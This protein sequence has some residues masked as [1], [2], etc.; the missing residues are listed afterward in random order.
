MA[1]YWTKKNS[2]K[3]STMVSQISQGI[4]ISVTSTY[5]SSS[6]KPSQR[7][8]IHA[9][10][11]T[12]ENLSE[13]TVQLIT[14]HWNIYDGRGTVREVSGPGVIGEQPVLASFDIHEYTSWCPLTTPVGKMNGTYGMKNLD[15]EAEF[16]V[17]VPEFK[18]IADHV[19]N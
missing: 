16:I 10:H 17:D 18:L 12:I 15:T 11:V 7:R 5:D 14:R 2:S 6:S 1:K 4:K 19:H 13:H 3:K 8:Y 9:Y